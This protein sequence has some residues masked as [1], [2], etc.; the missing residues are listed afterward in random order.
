MI[1]VDPETS[2]ADEVLSVSFN[3]GLE[4]ATGSRPERV[5]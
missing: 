5:F 3:V 2:A 4:L 1:D